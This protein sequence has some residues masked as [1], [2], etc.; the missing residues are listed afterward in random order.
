MLPRDIIVIGASAGG[1]ETCKRLVSLLS[2][3]FRGSIF[4]VI[5][6]P[7]NGVSLIP[8]ILS[9]NGPI[10]A[11]NPEDGTL[12][13]PGRIYVAPPDY[14]MLLKRGHI[15]LV[16]GPEENYSR[17]AVDPLFRSASASYG[18]RV[19]GV[20]LSGNLDDGTTGLKIIKKRGGIAVV[21]DPDEA[22]FPGMPLSA[23]S[24]IDV[25]YVLRI[26]QIAELLMSLPLVEATAVSNPGPEEHEYKDILEMPVNNLQEKILS[27]K[28]THFTCPQCGGILSEKVPGD[29]AEFRCRVGHAFSS[30]HLESALS[31]NAESALW[32]AIRVLEEKE[33]LYKRLATRMK[34]MKSHSSEI[35]FSKRG[36]AASKDAETIR[37]I[38]LRN[39]TSRE[40]EQ[41]GI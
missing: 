24:N 22:L 34:D 38:L 20:V 32:N 21:Q 31:T 16:S 4:I 26:D 12:I 39:E 25:D 10:P 7:S 2:P 11:I 5:H 41:A 36:N 18:S 40:G 13:E 29:S 37:S 30:G 6:L 19:V 8:E 17:P 14:H 3:E 1:L 27:A 23:I 9:K 33:E 35:H 28:P 15:R